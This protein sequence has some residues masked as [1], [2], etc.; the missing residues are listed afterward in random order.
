MLLDELNDPEPNVKYYAGLDI[1]IINDVTSS[2]Y[3]R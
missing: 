2:I 1:G 3:Y